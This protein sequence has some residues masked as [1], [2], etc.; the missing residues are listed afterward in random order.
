VLI[1]TSAWSADSEL[2]LPAGA[3]IGIIDMMTTDVTHFH[4]GKAPATSFLRTYRVGGT[5]VDVIDEPLAKQLRNAGFQPMPLAAS[6]TLRRSREAW[7]VASP[8]AR[9][10]PRACLDELDRIMTSEMLSALVVIAPGQ[11]TSPESV[12]GNRLRKLPDYM[13]GWGFST[14]DEVGTIPVVFNLAQMLLVGK[15]P[16]GAKLEYREWGG[17]YVYEWANF[18]PGPDLKA[19]P[20]SEITKFR[21]VITDVVQRQIAR[22]MP[23]IAT[24]P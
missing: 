23:H 13:Q 20:D 14:T 1:C 15:T 5:A 3:R 12:Q 17:S 4:V 19:I 8:Q 9:K 24:A 11:N 2:A 18:T 6:D 7:M 21:P 10:L 16:D 22:L